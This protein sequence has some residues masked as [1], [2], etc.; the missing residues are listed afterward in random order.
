MSIVG[1]CIAWN[2]QRYE[3][4]FDYDLSLSLLLEE[5][6]ELYDAKDVIEVLDA[7]GDI[8]FVTIGIMWKLGI[9][10]EDIYQIFYSKNLNA[11]SNHEAFEYYNE[12]LST[13]LHNYIKTFSHEERLILNFALCQVFNTCLS[14]L[15]GL[16]MQAPFYNIVDAICESNNTKEIKGKTASNIKANINKGS[17]YIAPTNKLIEIYSLYNTN[18]VGVA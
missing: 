13:F 2:K 11:F 4:E 18:V 6:Q 12:E 10:E 5:T 16:N 7:V 15:R 8:T 3:K 14:T 9:D 1:K 17:N